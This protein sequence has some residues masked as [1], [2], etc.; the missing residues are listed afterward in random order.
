LYI[1]PNSWNRDKYRCLVL[2]GN[3]IKRYYLQPRSV[4]EKSINFQTLHLTKLL[5]W[6]ANLNMGTISGTAHIKKAFSF[7]PGTGKHSIDNAFC[8]SNNSVMQLIY[9]L[10]FFTT[11]NVFYRLQ[12]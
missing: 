4:S 11:N 3:N 9:I 10:H 1:I 2:N 5:M 8:S 12:E 7:S 6:S